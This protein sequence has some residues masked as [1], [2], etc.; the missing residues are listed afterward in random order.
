MNKP[1]A[2]YLT[3][4]FN[5]AAALF[6]NGMEQLGRDVAAAGND[7]TSNIP[8]WDSAYWYGR[9]SNCYNY[10][11]NRPYGIRLQPGALARK[12]TQNISAEMDEYEFGSAIH[13]NAQQDGLVYLGMDFTGF[14]AFETHNLAALFI[15]AGRIATGD[16]LDPCFDFH[17]AALRRTGKDEGEKLV[18]A[19][20]SG[21]SP[22]K[23]CPPGPCAPHGS[24][25]FTTML[26]KYPI[27]AGYYAVPHKLQSM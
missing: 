2:F 18:W 20:K 21:K 19:H 16:G 23:T 27:F 22:V 1:H 24:D 11:L 6:Q 10:A 9:Y 25:L 8:H 5:K 3:D 26:P 14:K 17:W 13:N 15:S 7:L 4:D 12:R